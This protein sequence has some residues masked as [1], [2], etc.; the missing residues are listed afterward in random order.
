MLARHPLTQDLLQESVKTS[1]SLGN[2]SAQTQ[3]EKSAQLMA[4]NKAAAEKIL[5]ALKFS[6]GQQVSKITVK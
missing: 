2:G 1:T 6:L 5:L 4:A 3:A